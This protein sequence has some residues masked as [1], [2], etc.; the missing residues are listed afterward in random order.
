MQWQ[1]IQRRI[2]KTKVES[3]LLEVFSLGPHLLAGERLLEKLP[4]SGERCAIFA[5]L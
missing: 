3:L 2:I 1:S 4:T 5:K